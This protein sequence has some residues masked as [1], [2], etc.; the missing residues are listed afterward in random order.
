MG[1]NQWA[2]SNPS[3]FSVCTAGSLPYFANAT[4][5]G[6]TYA[7]TSGTRGICYNMQTGGQVTETI[8]QESLTVTAYVNVNVGTNVTNYSSPV[9]VQAPGKD[10]AAFAINSSGQLELECPF[11][12]TTVDYPILPATLAVANTSYGVWLQYVGGGVHSIKIYSNP[13]TNPALIGTASCPSQGTNYATQVGLGEFHSGAAGLTGTREFDSLMWDISGAGINIAPPGNTVSSF[14][15]FESGSN[16]DTVTASVLNAGTHGA[17]VNQWSADVGGF[18]VCTSGN[19][20]AYL[21]TSVIGGSTYPAGAG[22]RGICYNMQDGGEALE[23]MNSKTVTL[24]V[25]VNLGANATFYS[26]PVIIGNF[27]VDDAAFTLGSSGLLELECPF[28]SPEDYPISGANQAQANTTYGIWLQ[29]NSAIGHHTIKIYSNP[30][31]NPQLIGTATCPSQGSTAATK[32][33]FG[34]FHG[35]A[36]GQV[37]IRA[38]DSFLWDVSG[39]GINVSPA[40]NAVQLTVG[41][42]PAGLSYNVDGTQYS[43]PQ[44]LTWTIGTQHTLTTTASQAPATGTQDTFVNWSD[45]ITSVSDT[46]TATNGSAN[47]TANFNSSYQLTTA[48]SPAGTGSVTPTSGSYY[49]AGSVVPLTA[50]A[51]AGYNFS[52]WTGSVASPTSA[53]TTVTMGAPETVT[54][55]FAL[56]TQ[57]PA[58]ISANNTAFT[59]NV[60]G[61]FPVVATGVPAPSVKESGT[62]PKGVSF[63][64]S[65][66]LLSGTPASGT[67]GTYTITFTASNGVGTNAVQSFTLTV[68]NP[69]APTLTTVA[70]NSGQPGASVPITLT[71]TNFAATGTTVAV[72]G[73]GITVG[74][75]TV[76]NSTTIMTTFT[77]SATAASGARNVT[78]AS[79]GSTS[80]GQTFTV[81]GPTLTAIAPN[82]GARG[83]SVP[84]TLSGSGLTG[85]SAIAVSGSGVTSSN[86]VVVNDS[87]VTATFVISSS[88]TLSARTVSVTLSTG[89]IS[90]TVTFTVVNPSRPTLATI[91]PNTFLRG[92][93]TT[94]VTL[95]GT[96]FTTTGTSVSVSR[97]TGITV[98]AITVTSSTS[99]TATLA[100]AGG[101]SASLGTHSVTVSNPSGSSNSVSITVDG[102]T[103]TSISPTSG[104][105]G[106]TVP[107]TL[108]GTNLTGATAVTFS[109]SGV[110]CTAITSTSTTVSASCAIS[111]GARL[112]ARS[113][114]ATTPIGTTNSLSAAFTIN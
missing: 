2:L 6:A 32:L 74:S 8:P 9:I 55:K 66:N 88:A 45:G 91:A 1:I 67:A 72:S 3:G 30:T 29:Y 40:G 109:G 53:S 73:T 77:I 54:A 93:T 64:S 65:T 112:G 19:L 41:T 47:Y 11:A 31:T 39:N 89:G 13:T 12:G 58:I 98:S 107:V 5:N 26:N 79:S 56:P 96:N 36:V 20:P 17:G 100:I 60:A 70:P 113:V 62:L 85:A 14:S 42:N 33:G 46:V 35:G 59:V 95:T 43:N 80:N 105:H 108:A 23:S 34:E 51:N 37:G 4:T 38:F 44:I 81:I 101:S 52:G 10:A 21:S 102:A 68:V 92:T 106:T 78:V 110:N 111:T 69:A 24:Y 104:T 28:A 97:S 75:V 61:S 27:G 50:T 99:L 16:G 86:L 49:P 57:A 87:T 25:N 84:I 22:T 15:D 48:V 76:V 83:T 82:S 18:T 7:P 103:L 114:T 71:G 94:S 63:N 90:N